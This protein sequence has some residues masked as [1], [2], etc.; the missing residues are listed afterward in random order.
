MISVFQHR[1]NRDMFYPL[2]LAIGLRYTRAKRHSR[3]VSFTALTSMIGVAL[4]VAVLIT[5][6]SVMNGFDEQ[7]HRRFFSLAAQVTVV[8]EPNMV[9]WIGLQAN[10][11]QSPEVLGVAPT[12]TGQALLAI[13]GRSQHAILSGILPAKETTVS[14]LA[15]KMVLG[16]LNDLKPGEF[17]IVLGEDLALSLGASLG[18][19]VTVL[20][21]TA[22]ISL[23]G[24][25]P[26]VK[27]FRVVGL[28]KVGAGFG[29]D[30]HLALIHLRDGQALFMLG[31]QISGLRLKVRNVY[32]AP[33]TAARLQRQLGEGYRVEDWSQEY[34]AF[35]QAVKMEKTMTFSIL[36]LII[37]VAVFSMISSLVMVVND[38]QSDIAILR[39]LGMVPQTILRIF[40]IQ[41]L[42]IGFI[43]TALGV[44]LGILLA[45]NITDLANWIQ[46]ILQIELLSS[47]V[48]LVDYLP[49]RLMGR[50]IFHV[51]FVAL[52]LS[53]IATLYP[54][55]KAARTQPAEALR[56]D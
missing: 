53:F 1:N 28:F 11:L 4:G 5:V 51:C 40:M 29:F 41:G 31:S 22:T 13:G 50:D 18:S 7:L 49:T 47:N 55:W 2:S 48:Y 21:P 37:A 3:F 15:E 16:S 34:G 9:D 39:T 42:V 35:F 43:G 6:L 30:E 27:A 19:R 54:A 26:R 8:K 23:V 52:G 12:V 25:Q 36:C 46:R 24:A 56:Y 10:L 20:V 32:L 38:K 17:G 33:L 44:A 45:V 14:A